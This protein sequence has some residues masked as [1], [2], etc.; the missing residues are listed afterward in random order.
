M[1]ES[2]VGPFDVQLITS[3]NPD[4]MAM[5]LEDNE[6]D[7]TDRGLELIEPYVLEGMKFV[8]LKLRSGQSAGSIQPVILRYQS[9][10]PMIPI[11]L[12][13]VAAQE[14][15]G[16]LVWICLLYTSPSP[17]DKRQSRMPSSA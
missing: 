17:R 6:Y 5:W 13:A 10:K 1:E 8:G 12:T 11:R 9:D 15:M 16:V 2:T 7:L 14:D 4:S 3:E